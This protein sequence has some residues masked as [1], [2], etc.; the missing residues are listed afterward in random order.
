[1]KEFFRGIYHIAKSKFY[2][3]FSA[4][5]EDIIVSYL[6]KSVGI[7]KIK[8][9]DV[10][11]SSPIFG[12]NT[13]L[14]YKNGSTGVCIEA[15]PISYNRIKVIRKKD[16]CINAALSTK[17]SDFIDFYIFSDAGISTVVES[18][19]EY[20]E[21]FGSFYVE[22]KIKIPSFEINTLIQNNF[23]KFPDF[24]SIDIEGMDFLVLQSLDY[25][26]YPIPVIC[27]ETVAYA[28]NYKRTKQNEIIDFMSTKGY[29]LYA[30][31]FINSILV[32][33]DWFE[34]IPLDGLP[35]W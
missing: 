24:M 6:F 4:T 5:G 18:E 29:F 33:K 20:R 28:E 7:N 35:K 13:Y 3:S 21:S 19:A 15:N 31:T 9:L 17:N 23:E 25:T 8:Y 16:K 27:V 2:N 1:M 30:D 11:T 10:G 12:S 34:N 26:R 14:F 32:H 22:K